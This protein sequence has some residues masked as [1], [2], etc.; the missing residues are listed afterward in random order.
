VRLQ[1]PFGSFLQDETVPSDAQR[2]PWLWV[3]GG[4]GITPFIAV[5]SH[6]VPDRPLTLVYLVGDPGAAAFAD[7]LQQIADRHPQLTLLMQG[8][9]NAAADLPPLLDRVPHLA[10]CQVRACGP[11][12]LVQALREALAA[13]G[14]PPGA[15]QAERF[16]FR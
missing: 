7:E 11:A 10:Q 6:A 9:R 12:P 2:S 3:A 13:R 1:G 15:V 16:D 5:L 14:L 4:I 8:S